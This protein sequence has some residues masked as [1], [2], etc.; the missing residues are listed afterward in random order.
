MFYSAGKYI[1]L[2]FNYHRLPA[3]NKP[4]IQLNSSSSQPLFQDV[5]KLKY[6]RVQVYKI[7]INIYKTLHCAH[8]RKHAT[9]RLL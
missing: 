2:A 4:F 7:S 8:S 6:C 3:F 9:N 5:C 1:I